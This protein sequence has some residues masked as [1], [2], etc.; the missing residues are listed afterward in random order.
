MMVF[1]EIE[2]FNIRQFKHKRIDFRT[3]F[4]LI[5]IGPAQGKSTLTESLRTALSISA[6]N[7]PD[8]FKEETSDSAIHL[9]VLINRKEYYVKKEWAAQKLKHNVVTSK[10]GKVTYDLT[11]S[12]QAT[13][14]VCHFLKLADKMF[15]ESMETTPVDLL[16]QRYDVIC[17][18]IFPYNYYEKAADSVWL[19]TLLNIH[20]YDHINSELN[21]IQQIASGSLNELKMSRQAA[22]ADRKIV[23]RFEEDLRHTDHQI[24]QLLSV[25]D[26]VSAGAQADEAEL[27]QADKIYEFIVAKKHEIE[28]I[29]FELRSYNSVLKNEIGHEFTEDEIQEIEKK[30]KIYEQISLQEESLRK[31]IVERGHLE[32]NLNGILNEITQHQISQAP[33]DTGAGKTKLDTYKSEVKRIRETLKSYS[34]LEHDME[35]AKRE[36]NLYQSSHDK[37]LVIGKLKQFVSQNEQK[38]VKFLIEKLEQDRGIIVKELEQM[39][40]TMHEDR[41]RN[42]FSKVQQ[43]RQQIIEQRKRIELLYERRLETLRSFEE[44]VSAEPDLMA[45][46]SRFRRQVH[47]KKYLSVITEVAQFIQKDVEESRTAEFQQHI[48]NHAS[49]LPDFF[50]QLAGYVLQ[51]QDKSILQSQVKRYS[52]SQIAEF[53]LIFRLLCIDYATHHSGAVLDE[54]YRW[55][56]DPAQ[57]SRID[58]LL[59]HLHFEQCIAFDKA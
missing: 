52:H 38:N 33:S 36:K 12:A 11:D 45:M 54:H 48:L 18:L 1:K 24:K 13:Q 32:K 7:P 2:L 6:V 35:A 37:H 10:D 43:F 53:N 58:T 34:S 21:H 59:Q 30:K 28:R 41:Y 8:Y 39:Q 4:N 20:L 29:D 3:G 19:H 5:A 23:E 16:L 44:S 56:M 50:L 15:N 42:L 46:E 27:R 55:L 57:I 47:L 26:Q 31:K 25:I 14:W 51:F 17:G 22:I 40:S 49:I 9:V